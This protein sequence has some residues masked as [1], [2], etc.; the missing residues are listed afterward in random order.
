MVKMFKFRKL[1]CIPM[2][3]CFLV[4]SILP[5]AHPDGMPFCCVRLIP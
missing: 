1:R 4:F 2:G 5:I 3:C